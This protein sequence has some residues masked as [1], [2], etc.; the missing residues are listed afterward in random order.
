MLGG[1][2]SLALFDTDFW[3]WEEV[4]GVVIYFN[5][6]QFEILLFYAPFFLLFWFN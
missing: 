1:R 2:G 4:L 3:K 6:D 5:I